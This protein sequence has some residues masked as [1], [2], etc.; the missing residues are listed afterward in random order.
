MEQEEEEEVKDTAKKCEWMALS[1]KKKE[2]LQSHKNS[3]YLDS[4]SVYYYSS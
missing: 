2:K 3:L 1:W 4:F